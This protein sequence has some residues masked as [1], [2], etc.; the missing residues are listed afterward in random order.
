MTRFLASL[1]LA[2]SMLPIAALQ[3][4]APKAYKTAYVDMEKVFEGYYKT[5]QANITFATEKR[6]FLARLKLMR[7]ELKP[8]E[9]KAKTLRA[10]MKDDLVPGAKEDAA[11]EYRILMERGAAKQQEYMRF[12]Q[13]G[14]AQV[15]KKRMEAEGALIKDLSEFI[16]KYC[17]MNGYDIVYDI[18][19]KSLNRMPVLLVYPK[20]L[21]ITDELAKAVNLG[22]EEELKK[23]REELKKIEDGLAE[24]LDDK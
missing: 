6:D 10:Q 5:V 9:E 8:L 16:R 22:H 23:A 24:D 19:G 7:D 12:R 14:R 2:L 15:E 3:A 4:Q 1:A 21:E 17:E 20:E 11:R 13:T 18:N